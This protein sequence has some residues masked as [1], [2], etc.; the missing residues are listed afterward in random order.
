MRGITAVASAAAVIV[1]VGLFGD[2]LVGDRVF[3]FRDSIHTFPA[4][5][6]LIRAEWLAGRVPLWNPLLNGGQPLAAMNVPAAFY[7]P[8]LLA[9]LV[10]PTGLALTTLALAH[11]AVGAAGSCAVARNEGLTPAAATIAGLAYACGGV[12]AFQVYHPN[13]AIGAGWFPWIVWAGL[14]LARR[15]SPNDFLVLAVSLALAVLGGDPQAAYNAG[16]VLVVLIACRTPAEP[17]ACDGRL[18]RIAA[19]A[20]RLTAA[21]CLAAALSWVQVALTREFMSETSRYADAFPVSAWDIPRFLREAD[22]ADRVHWADVILGR[23]PPGAGFYHQIYE[24]SVAPWRFLD[25]VNP[26]LAGPLTDRWTVA[27]R[28]EGSGSWVA[29]LYSGIVPLACVCLALGWRRAEA[30]RGWAVVL[31]VAYLAAVGGFGLGAVVRHVV[32]L[33]NGGALPD[34][35]RPGDEVG[36]LSWLMA[37]LLPGYAGFRSPGK[38]LTPAALAFA[39]LAARGCDRATVADGPRALRRM[40]APIAIAVAVVASASVAAAPATARAFVISG[41]LLAGAACGAAWAALRMREA[42]RLTDRSLAAALVLITAVDLVA[43]GRTFVASAPLGAV[44]EG[45]GYLGALAGMRLPACAAAGGRPRLMA[46]DGAI[47]IPPRETAVERA[48]LVG[49]AMRC[50]TPLLHGWGKFGE[51]GTAMQADV[52]LLTSPLET[53]AGGVFPR[54]TFDMA[55]VEF[56]V[57]PA[58]PPAALPLRELHRD[59]SPAQKSGEIAGLAPQGPEMPSATPPPPA[60]ARPL[61]AVIRNESALPRV[62]V[63]RDVLAVPPVPSR[64]RRA[65]AAFLADRAFPGPHLPRPATSAVVETDDAAAV[66]DLRP[67][68]DAAVED[69]CRITADEPR[70]VIVEAELASAGLVVLADAFHPDWTAT[71][72]ADGGDPRPLGILRVNRIQRGCLLPAGS[73]VVEFRHRSVTCERAVPIT[74]AAWAMAVA[75]AAWSCRRPW[76]V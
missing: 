63:V 70:R 36:G 30:L 27:R 33:V 68:G 23:P 52:E 51:P 72:R 69:S 1:V 7:P 31:G 29:T 44:R 41:G 45:S 71:V 65:W 54:R 58:D 28:F 10:M 47:T 75:A 62:R 16:I 32:D 64:P 38:W 53:R 6:E 46:V 21:A 5:G 9:L 25:V 3:A 12:V 48:R 18:G 37:T 14:R 20:G 55:A 43:S 24:F 57:V 49:L 35:Y 61:V 42:G 39:Q 40:L 26:T 8:Q 60:G 4:L 11:L 56:F 74:L 73:H 2:A 34:P 67:G 66:A 59:W 15:W 17:G 13:T 76:A 22:A 50:N 19:A